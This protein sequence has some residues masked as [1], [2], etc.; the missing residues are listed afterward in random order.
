MQPACKAAYRSKFSV[1]TQKLLSAARFDPGTSRAAGKRAITRPLQ[2]VVYTVAHVII[3]IIII[4]IIMRCCVT[5]LVPHF[6]Q[7]DAA[8][9]G[10]P[11]ITDAYEKFDLE[12]S[13]KPEAT[14]GQKPGIFLRTKFTARIIVVFDT[15]LVLLVCS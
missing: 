11:G 13:F 9:I 2:P 7:R 5:E 4:I 1:K 8:Y 10:Y 12:L 3:I 15:L 6:E 14:D